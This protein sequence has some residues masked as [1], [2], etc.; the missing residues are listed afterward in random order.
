MSTTTQTITA[1]GMTCGHCVQS[2][3]EAI[4]R[5]DGVEDVQVRLDDGTITVGSMQPL[6]RDQLR[7]A[8]RAAGYTPVD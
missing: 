4:Q 1:T 8:V 7:D 6:E 3:T 2:V 5:L